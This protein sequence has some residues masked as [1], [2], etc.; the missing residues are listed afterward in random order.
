MVKRVN[1]AGTRPKNEVNSLKTYSNN[2]AKQVKPLKIHIG[3]S[4]TQ[5]FKN[6]NQKPPSVTL[7]EFKLS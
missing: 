7:I 4:V 5:S 6:Q 1:K 2:Q 3:Q